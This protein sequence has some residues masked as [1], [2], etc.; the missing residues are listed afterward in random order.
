METIN[1]KNLGGWA[2]GNNLFQ[3]MYETYAN[4]NKII[5]ELGSGTGSEELSKIFTVYSIEHDK[6][7]M[8]RYNTNYIYAPLIDGWYD[9]Q[10]VEAAISNIKYD[11]L[12]I[13]GPPQHNRQNIKNFMH[14]FDPTIP[15]IFDD[16]ERSPIRELADT[17]KEK[18]DTE[19]V[20]ISEGGRK[21]ST[22]L[23]PK[24]KL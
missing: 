21:F 20:E 15:W 1:N 11:L 5:L 17:H 23:I 9:P 8:D 6:N 4:K 7:W 24:Q 12:L 18:Y 14:L 3:Y 13:D 10:I 22:I 19:I 16:S 2:I